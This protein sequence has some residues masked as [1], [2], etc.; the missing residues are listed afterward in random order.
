M[1][2]I[3]IS[4]ES[5]KL[6]SLPEKVFII[7]L[8]IDVFGGM[9]LG[10]MFMSKLAFLMSTIGLVVMVLALIYKIIFDLD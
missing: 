2:D 5:W 3:E 10:F 6:T 9:C 7:V 8:A 4:W 1:G